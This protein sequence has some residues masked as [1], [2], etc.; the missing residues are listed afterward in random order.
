MDR[1]SILSFESSPFTFSKPFGSAR[2][3]VFKHVGSSSAYVASIDLDGSIHSHDMLPDG[4]PEEIKAAFE[5]YKMTRPEYWVHEGFPET[6]EMSDKDKYKA[7]LCGCALLRAQ[8]S[9]NFNIEEVLNR[10]DKII[11][12]LAGTDFFIAPGSTIYHDSEPGGLMKHSLRVVDEIRELVKVPKFAHHVSVEDAVLVALLHDWCKIGRYEQF[13]KNVKNEDTGV[14]E[15]VPAYKHTDSA[16]PFGHGGTSLFMASKMFKLSTA[17]ALAIN[18]HM[19]P[20]YCHQSDYNDLQNA[21]ENY[22]LVHLLQFA[23][24][25]SITN[26]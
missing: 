9:D 1:D 10:V 6:V 14:W 13:M 20:W 25:L 17:E 11:N 24:Q 23:D 7:L 3:S 4:D 5:M 12:W 8:R 21:N 2:Y 22:P 16:F 15:K 26:Y 19:G 18:W